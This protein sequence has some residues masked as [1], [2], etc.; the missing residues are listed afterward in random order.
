MKKGLVS[1]PFPPPLSNLR[2][3]G[4]Y[5][6]TQREINA[7]C[8]FSAKEAKKKM[9]EEIAKEKT[10]STDCLKSK[11]NPSHFQI[12]V[13]CNLSTEYFKY[14]NSSFGMNAGRDSLYNLTKIHKYT[15]MAWVPKIVD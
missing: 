13:I 7:I 12:P 3:G 5:H 11:E 10:I 6:R 15:T 2:F 1:L 9:E 8:S 4:P 14:S